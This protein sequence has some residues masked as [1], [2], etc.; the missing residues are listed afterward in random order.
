MIVPTLRDAADVWTLRV[1]PVYLDLL[2][3]HVEA[4]D[5]RVRLLWCL[6]QL[7]DGHHRVRVVRQHA[8]HGVHLNTTHTT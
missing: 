3:L 4:A 5:V 2:Y 1:L 6:V 8:H 7:H